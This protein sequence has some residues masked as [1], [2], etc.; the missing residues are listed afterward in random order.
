MT[1]PPPTVIA[2]LT[3]IRPRPFWSVMIPCYNRAHYLEKALTSVL[4]QDPGPEEMQIAVV[5][6]ASTLDDPEVVVR[7]LAGERAVFFRQPRNLGQFGNVNDC[8]ER[9]RGQWVH[10]LHSDDVVFPGFY[11]TLKAALVSRDDIGAAYCRGSTID[12]NGALKRISVAE[13]SEPGV[14]P[15]FIATIGARNK[16]L[17]PSIVVRRSVYEKLGGY[18]LDLPYAADWEMWIRIAAH[19][20]IWYEPATLAAWRIHSGSWS[21]L[22]LRS[23]QNIADAR[24]CIEISHSLLPRED[25]AALSRKARDNLARLAISDAFRALLAGQFR[26]A[27]CQAWEGLK[28]R[29]S[30]RVAIRTL[31][32]LPLR[33]AEETIRRVRKAA[34]RQLAR[35]HSA[36]PSK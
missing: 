16:I 36:Q 15:R 2:P 23:G 18:R 17:T 10:I 21:T 27:C 24:H 31:L 14:L 6:D 30:P 3:D 22:H 33:I 28:C 11:A 20:P 7:R 9:A 8:L 34:K 29:L 12:E 1:Y 13:S 32:L 5:D 19:Y 35:G 26:A 4:A 25:A